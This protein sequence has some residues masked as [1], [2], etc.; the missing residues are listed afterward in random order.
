MSEIDR[1]ELLTNPARIRH[2]ND[3]VFGARDSQTFV[4]RWYGGNRNQI[5]L[6][7]SVFAIDPFRPHFLKVRDGWRFCVF[8]G[9]T[10]KTGGRGRSIRRAD[11]R[12]GDPFLLVR[13]SP[14]HYSGDL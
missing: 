5:C 9:N 8:G 11:G 2:K 12:G 6:F 14:Q 3:A 1:D 13:P 7:F 4:P 10:S